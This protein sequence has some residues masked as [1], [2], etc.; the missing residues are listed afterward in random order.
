MSPAPPE[1]EAG[2]GA[3]AGA[4]AMIEAA[5]DPAATLDA[6]GTPDA[7]APAFLLRTSGSTGTPAFLVRSRESWRRCFAAEAALL[8]LTGAERVLALGRP[9]FSLTVYA[10]LRARHLGAPFAWLDAVRPGAARATLAELAP[11][12]VYGVPPLI[13][14]LAQASRGTTGP[15]VPGPRLAITGGA[16]LTPGQAAAIRAAWPQTRVVTFYGAAETSFITLQPDPDPADPTAVGPL[17][18]GVRVATAEDGR[19]RVWTPYAASWR[20]APDGTRTPVADPDGAVTLADRARLDA[21]GRLHLHGRADGH[22]NLGGALVDPAPIEQALEALPWVAE[23]VLVPRADARRSE[24]A[25]AV[26][27]V[28]DGVPD[29]AR[30]SLRAALPAGAP[31]RGWAA[32]HDRLPRTA[33]G[34]PDRVALAAALAAGTP[35]PF[36]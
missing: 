36:A 35:A 4:G 2:A 17:V 25:V 10:A 29:S 14:A 22:L 21:N 9:A 30:E 33:G 13:R 8:G 20:I 32:I 31:V 28:P 11:T 23:A 19:L 24:A 15:A 5:V 1:A 3:G 7:E 34:K 6:G 18:P 16:R 12:I 26:V 27:L